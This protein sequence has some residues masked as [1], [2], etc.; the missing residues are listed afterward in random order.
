MVGDGVND[1][2][3]LKRANLG[4]AMQS[5]SQAARGV[6]DLVLMKDSFGV[7]PSAFREGQRILNGMQDILNIFTVRI[8]SR[9]LVMPFVAL[10]GGFAFS[11]RQSALL[12]YLTATV[13]TIGLIIWAQSGQTIKG[14]IY[15]PLARFAVP[16]TI[17]LAAFELAV[18][19]LYFKTGEH[20]F[21][22]AHHGATTERPCR[23]PCPRR[24]P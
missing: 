14:R 8:F 23:P 5:G 17:L 11:P 6:A 7:L 12:S 10:I 2:I 1:V 22:L 4:V 16:A 9:A 20:T 15:R 21:L 19:A 24:R 3:A 18:Y 13:P